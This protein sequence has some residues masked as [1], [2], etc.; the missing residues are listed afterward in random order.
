MAYSELIKNFSK[1]RAY[2]RDFYIYGF[3]NRNEYDQKSVRSYDNEKR[4]MESWLGEY[5][6][7]HQD[8]SGKNVFLSVDS[9]NIFRLT[10][11]MKHSRRRVL[12][13]EI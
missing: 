6:S 7:F 10:L 8:A 3:K 5:M 13:T 2:M 12:Q 1:I 4:R 9:R 11:C